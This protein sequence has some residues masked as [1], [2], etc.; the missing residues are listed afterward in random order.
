VN[1]VVVPSIS[2]AGSLLVPVAALKS[3]RAVEIFSVLVSASA[4]FLSIYFLAT[5]GEP[6]V[7]GPFSS[8]ISFYID[9]L[10]LFMLTVVNCLGAL[11]IFY[12]V[13][14]MAHDKNYT[15]YY[16]LMLLFVGSMSGLVLAGDLVLLYIFWEMVGICSALLIAFWWEKPEA[17]RAGLK[18]FA[19]TRIG[20]FAM[21]IGIALIYVT[22]GTT[23]IPEL[24]DAKLPVSLIYTASLM[25]F[26][27]AIGKSAQFPLFVWLPDAME[28]PTSVSALI[29]AATM[30]KAG[31]YLVA[32]IYPW[33][34]A[35]PGLPS[36]IL[37]V[38]IITVLISGF[39][40]LASN[41]IKRVLAYSTINHLALMFLALSLGGWA[42]AQLHLLSHSLFKALLFLATG[43]VV[44]EVGTRDMGQMG[45]LLSGGMKITAACFLVGALS[46]AGIPPL[47]GFTTKEHVLEL[48]EESLP[49]YAAAPL[50]FTISLTSALYIFRVFFKVFWGEPRKSY[51]ERN[52]YM[53][54]PIAA[55]A[56]V[57]LVG[58]A[59]LIQA[60]KYF[61][62]ELELFVVSLPA[63]LGT[64]LGV[65]G[66]YALWVENY[67]AKVAK[68]LSWAVK[69][70]EEGFYFDAVYTK[71]AA[72]VAGKVSSVAVRIQSGVPSVN[73]LWLL[74]YMLALLFVALM[75]VM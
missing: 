31:V 25:L 57:T 49:S 38:A 20:D 33:I 60:S 48:L 9:N 52:V 53:L 59:L 14:Y 72:F 13:G 5:F 56:A 26:I 34:E 3:R 12:S 32:R 74:A 35:A 70:A 17:R 58:D 28:G 71:V 30:V 51:S 47:P 6:Q 10:S 44:H 37:W 73:M 64:V 50:V 45:G 62:L 43:I 54:A 67:A 63:M 29:H 46:L 15:R 66:A 65:L 8:H 22:S 61:G 7:I 23:S 42:Y 4:A 69:A 11:I 21:L 40:A 1:P 36:I 55:L 16:F 68:S 39:S 24:L 19:V 18:A 41:D 27:G 75:V 2:L